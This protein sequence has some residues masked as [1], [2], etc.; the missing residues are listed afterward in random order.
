VSST[1]GV[2]DPVTLMSAV[3]APTTEYI[4]VLSKFRII[5]IQVD[6]SA[7]AAGTV[8]IG[9]SVNGTTFYD[10]YTTDL[11]ANSVD[12]IHI[13]DQPVQTIRIIAT[14]S[15]GTTTVVYSKGDGF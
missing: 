14:P 11:S 9:I 7:A 6:G 3:S 8:A 12:V 10:V 1:R 15:A 4:R 5:A 13:V 2:L